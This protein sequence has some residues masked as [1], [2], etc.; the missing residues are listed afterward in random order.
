VANFVYIKGASEKHP[1]FSP[2]PTIDLQ[3]PQP[4]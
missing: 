1:D 2:Q 3:N 4:T